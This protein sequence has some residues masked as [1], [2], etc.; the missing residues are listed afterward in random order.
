VEDVLGR[1][2]KDL[3]ETPRRYDEE[4]APTVE[5]ATPKNDT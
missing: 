3:Y 4:E 5:G 1:N 2:D